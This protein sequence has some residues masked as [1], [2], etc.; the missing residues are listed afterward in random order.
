MLYANE[1]RL[2]QQPL[3]SRYIEC[4]EGRKKKGEGGYPPCLCFRYLSPFQETRREQ[5]DNHNDYHCN[6]DVQL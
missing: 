1:S 5:D 6:D 3:D 4:V 2:L